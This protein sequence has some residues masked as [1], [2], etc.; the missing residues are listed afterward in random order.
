MPRGLPVSTGRFQDPAE[1]AKRRNP[2]PARCGFSSFRAVMPLVSPGSNEKSKHA[3]GESPRAIAILRGRTHPP[4]FVRSLSPW[5]T[6]AKEREPLMAA[7]PVRPFVRRDSPGSIRSG[8]RDECG[9]EILVPFT[10]STFRAFTFP[11]FIIFEI[12]S[13]PRTS[14]PGIG[15]RPSGMAIIARSSIRPDGPRK[16]A[17]S[18]KRIRPSWTARE[19]AVKTRRRGEATR[20]EGEVEA[21]L[22]PSYRARRSPRIW[23]WLTGKEAS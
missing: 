6:E 8:S 11:S 7:A 13:H 16:W 18:G 2:G 20:R 17:R 3:G 19:A 15:R 5:A 23:R 14:G 1:V 12:D 21:S 22:H 4:G 10:L 9:R